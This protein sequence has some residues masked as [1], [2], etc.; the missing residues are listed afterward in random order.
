MLTDL[1]GKKTAGGAGE[2]V[3]VT[4]DVHQVFRVTMNGNHVSVT[5]HTNFQGV[6]RTG[7]TTGERIRVVVRAPT[8]STTI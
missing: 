4:G 6:T 7:L 2:V 1:R 8:R 3:H 5:E